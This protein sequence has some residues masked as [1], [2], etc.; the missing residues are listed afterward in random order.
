MSGRIL[1]EISN[2]VTQK[3]DSGKAIAKFLGISEELPEKISLAN[4]AALVLSSK[5]DAYYYTS[6]DSCT[7]PAGVHNK[8][9]KHRRDLCE[10]AREKSEPRLARMIKAAKDNA[11]SKLELFGNKPFKPVL[12]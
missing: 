11:G 6:L 2:P 10:A 3:I 7:C 1:V 5:A 4:G 9:C 8:I 12:E